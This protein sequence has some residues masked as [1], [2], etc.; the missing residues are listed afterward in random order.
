MLLN[1]STLNA[2]KV[3]IGTNGILGGSGGVV[4][5]SEIIN[6]GIFS[7][8]SSPGIF[9]IN[10]NYTAGAG[11]KLILEVD[12]NGSGGFNT[13]Q[14]LF[15]QGNSIDL[16][17]LNIEFRFLGNTDPNAFKASG[18]F[19]ID[20]FLGFSAPGGSLTPLGDTTYNGVLFSATATA[21]TIGNFSYN[22]ASTASFTAAPVPE[23]SRWAMIFA[24]VALLAGV[25]K[26]SGARGV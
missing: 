22:A 24:G 15:T 10:G 18:K 16:R 25:A 7:P 8:G 4:N 1:N 3:V 12:A 21:Y 23:P 14:V 11:S 6:Y 19:D 2:T 26:R 9:T 13:D 17:A 5:A 20:T